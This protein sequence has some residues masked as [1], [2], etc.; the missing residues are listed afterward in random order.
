MTWF[1]FDEQICKL[2][3][4]SWTYPNSSINVDISESDNPNT[5]ANYSYRYQNRNMN[6]YGNS[7]FEE[8]YINELEYE[9]NGVGDNW[10]RIRVIEYFETITFS[11]SK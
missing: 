8:W 1:P 5:S 2:K 6:L 9:P 4:G 11:P 3:F 10:A 7:T